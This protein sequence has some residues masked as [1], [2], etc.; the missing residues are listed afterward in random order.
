[1]NDIRDVVAPAFKLN[2]SLAVRTCLPTLLLGKFQELLDALILR[3]QAVMLLALTSSTC[4]Y[5][6]VCTSTDLCL[7]IIG[8]DPLCALAAVCS[9]HCSKLLM[10][11]HEARNQGL[12][13][14][15]RAIEGWNDLTAAS[16]R[17][18]GRVR[19]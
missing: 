18:I 5:F 7:D 3:T 16:R 13:Q 19:E 10:P 1:M 15:W 17:E 14:K 6:A 12:R 4:L 11:L 9:I 2:H 8:P